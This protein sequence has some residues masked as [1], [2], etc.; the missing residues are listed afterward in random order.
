MYCTYM[1]CNLYAVCTLRLY[2]IYAFLHSIITIVILYCTCA[3]MHLYIYY[4]SILYF[5][6]KVNVS[7]LVAM[8]IRNYY[9]P[10]NFIMQMI[11]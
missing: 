9:G 5:I 8:Y 11:N 2:T 7:N 10:I 1:H 3:K 4:C 6:F